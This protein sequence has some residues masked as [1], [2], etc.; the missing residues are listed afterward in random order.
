MSN[1]IAIAIHKRSKQHVEVL[2]RTSSGGWYVRFPNQ[3]GIQWKSDAVF[4]RNFK[5]VKLCNPGVQS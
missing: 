5:L 3:A 4:Y 2:E 1:P